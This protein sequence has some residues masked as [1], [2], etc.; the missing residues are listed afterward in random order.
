MDYHLQLLTRTMIMVLV[1]IK[2]G[3]VQRAHLTSDS[4]NYFLFIISDL[5]MIYVNTLSKIKNVLLVEFSIT[6][7]YK[8]YRIE[9]VADVGRLC[10]RRNMIKPFILTLSR[11]G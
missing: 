1:S 6:P 2:N 10:F 3:R 11:Y 4:Y 8:Y 9:S 5:R 7:L